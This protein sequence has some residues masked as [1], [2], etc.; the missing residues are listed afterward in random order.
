MVDR[1][2]RE[3]TLAAGRPDPDDR[4]LTREYLAGLCG[5][6]LKVLDRSEQ[7]TATVAADLLAT[8]AAESAAIVPVRVRPFNASPHA[9]RSGGQDPLE[10]EAIGI[11]ELPQSGE[12]LVVG[13][14]GSGKSMACRNLC[15]CGLPPVY[16]LRLWTTAVTFRGSCCRAWLTS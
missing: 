6:H 1:L 2:W 9:L 16:L 3:L 13:P 10:T 11:A 4:I 14:T 15:D 8:I 5:L 12:M 7:W